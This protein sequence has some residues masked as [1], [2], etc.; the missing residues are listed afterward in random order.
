MIAVGVASPSAQG[1]A[2]IS[3]AIAAV[4]ACVSRG[5]GPTTSHPTNVSAAIP[6]TAG[7]K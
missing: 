3:T 2:T 5:S 4:S 6:S 1:Q 7:T